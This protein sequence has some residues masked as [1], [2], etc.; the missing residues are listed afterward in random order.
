MENLIA[1]LR[2]IVITKIQRTAKTPESEIYTLGTGEKCPPYL[3]ATI[4]RDK[5][6]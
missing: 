6:N 3:T 1:H 5:K 4:L 2:F